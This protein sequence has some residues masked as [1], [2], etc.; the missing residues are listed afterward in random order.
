MKET[1]FL[2]D[3]GWPSER[4]A[5][6]GQARWS[7]VSADGVSVTQATLERS[8]NGVALASVSVVSPAQTE[9]LLRLSGRVVGGEILALRAN[10]GDPP[11]SIDASDAADLFN[12]LRRGL[13]DFS[14]H[15]AAPQSQPSA[16]ASPFSTL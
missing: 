11:E 1:Q 13:P 8:G 7:G 14:F 4:L 3:L 2:M 6:P 10:A 16:T 15:P 12:F 9:S 5:E